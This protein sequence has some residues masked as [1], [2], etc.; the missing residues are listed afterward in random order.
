MEVKRVQAIASLSMTKNTIPIEFIRSETEQPAITTVQG[1]VLEVPL[2][3][4]NETNE[5]KV[6]ELIT[7]ASEEW[8]L[9]Q[10]VNHGIPNEVITRLREAGREFFELPQDEKEVYAKPSDSKDIEGYGTKLQKEVE[11]KKAWVDHLF[12]RTWP[13]SAINYKFWPKN[14]SYYREANEQYTECL[15]K[16][17]E[18]LFKCLSLGL[19]LEGHELNEAVGGEDLVY[20][21]KINY[22]PPCPR[23]DLA[24]GVVAHTDMS[25]ITILVPND[26][27]GLQVCRDG[28]WSDV[29]YI[30]NALIV[31]IGDQLEAS[32]LSNG[33]YKAVL[34]RTT[35]NKDKTRMSWPVFLEPPADQEIGPHRKLVDE[36][37]NPAKYKTKKY[38]DYVHCKLNKI[39]Q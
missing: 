29:K 10:V 9:F 36:Q 19:K 34:H 15:R 26:V 38:S 5:D 25:A 1:S 23:P 20:M 28:Q 32:V 31:H 17:S 12:H 8:G 30:P 21:L 4:L 13:P 33:K 27:P 6:V 24:L 11:G 18:K 39:P 16:V 14:P 2:I 3:D 22:Y 7:K 35:V 37:E